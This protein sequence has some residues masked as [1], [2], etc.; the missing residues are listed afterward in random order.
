MEVYKGIFIAREVSG[1]EILSHLISLFV[2]VMEV[3]SQMLNK[4]AVEGLLP[5]HP[6]CDKIHLHLCFAD[7]LMVFTEACKLFKL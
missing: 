3:F 2:I 6:K 1:K 4:A 7:D 5:Y